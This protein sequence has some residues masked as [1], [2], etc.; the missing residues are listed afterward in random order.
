MPQRE[1]IPSFTKNNIVCEGAHMLFA[2][3]M[4]IIETEGRTFMVLFPLM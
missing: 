4:Q 1:L 3:S 2:R